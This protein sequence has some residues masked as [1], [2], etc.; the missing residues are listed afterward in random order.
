MSCE[1]R[2]S[3]VRRLGCW[4]RAP[5]SQRPKLDSWLLSP[6]RSRAPVAKRIANTTAKVLPCPH[7]HIPASGRRQGGPTWRLH[8]SQ[9]LL[10]LATP[11]RK[12]T[13]GLDQGAALRLWASW[14]VCTM[15][16]PNLQMPSFGDHHLHV[17]FFLPSSSFFSS[18][19]FPGIAP[20]RTVSSPTPASVSAAVC[21]LFLLHLGSPRS[22]SPPR[23][24]SPT[25]AT[26]P[27]SFPRPF[28][29]PLA[30]KPL[31][32]PGAREGPDLTARWKRGTSDLAAPA[33]LGY[34]PK[35][36]R[37]RVGSIS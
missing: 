5:E 21:P 18:F 6:L 13:E 11:S 37:G 12:G 2:Y 1:G 10:W 9:A 35:T 31:R 19:T 20:H 29:S 22:A 7:L 27:A 14:K 34:V 3:L 33:T 4:Y 24:I 26:S 15:G 36:P 23:L 17:F 16:G 30:M 32:G 8:I 25:S 28:L